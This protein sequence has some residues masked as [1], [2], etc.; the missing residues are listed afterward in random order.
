MS[1]RLAS[2]AVL[3]TLLFL[4]ADAADADRRL[5]VVSSRALPAIQS[6]TVYRSA[7][8]KDGKGGKK[9]VLT[10]TKFEEPA[11]LPGAGPFDVR[12]TPKGGIPFVA[13]G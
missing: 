12:V 3:T 11:V 1:H 6:V 8:A 13:A 2:A 4:P 5:K 10:I 9:P 7:D